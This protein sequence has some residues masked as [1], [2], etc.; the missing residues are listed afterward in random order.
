MVS[1]QALS[2]LNASVDP[3]DTVDYLDTDENG[4]EDY[5]EDKDGSGLQ[6]GFEKY[7]DFITRVLDDEPGVD[8]GQPLQPIRRAAGIAIIAG[9]NLLLQFLIF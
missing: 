9:I 1:V 8:V 6:D 4:T 7:P 2:L 3:S 5:A